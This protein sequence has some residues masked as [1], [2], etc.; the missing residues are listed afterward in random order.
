MSERDE[1]DVELLALAM[2]LNVPV[3]SNDGYFKDSGV[4][5]YTTARLLSILKA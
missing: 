2:K 5:L 1:D 3:W 4:E